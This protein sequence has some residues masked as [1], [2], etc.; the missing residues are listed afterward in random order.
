MA[1]GTDWLASFHAGASATMAKCYEDEFATVERAVG[2]FLTGVD[3]ETVV[4]DVFFRLLSDAELRKSFQGGVL[5]AW[6]STVARHQTI[7]YLRRQRR[8]ETLREEDLEKME[9]PA[10]ALDA[11]VAARQLVERFRAELPEKWQAVFDARF[12]Q[13]LNQ[14]EAAVALGVRRTTLAYQELRIRRLLRRF[15]LKTE[16]T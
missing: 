11:S 6:L 12:V 14:T 4:H 2:R 16:N 7:D 1:D 15:V 5:R 9:L 13:Q 3:R 8:V 10:P